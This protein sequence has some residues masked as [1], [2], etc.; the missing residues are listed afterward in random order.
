MGNKQGKKGGA[1]S[2]APGDQKKTPGLTSAEFLSSSGPT[3]PKP[4]EGE[5]EWEKSN[6]YMMGYEPARDVLN[7]K[8]TIKD[9]EL[10]KVVGK[11]SF[12]KVYQVKHIA[13]GEIYALKSLKKQHLLRRKQIAHTQT[14]RKVL[15]QIESPF[16]VNLRFAF[17]DRDRLYMVLDYFTGGEL[18]YHLKTGGRFGYQ[19]AR[20]Y[21][22]EIC[23][24]LECL[25]NN[26]IIYRDLKPE[27][28]LLD[29]EGHIRLTDFGLSKDCMIGNQ[30]TK[31]FCGT[32]EYLAPEVIVGKSYT[33]A[34]DW[35]SFGTVVY[36]MTCGLPPFYHKNVKAM[37]ERI[38]SAPLRFPR[39]MPLEGKDFF[40]KILDRNPKTRLGTKYGA[41]GV[42][43]SPY[44]SDVNWKKASQKEI[45]PLFVPR[46][47]EGKMDAINVDQEFLNEMPSETPMEGSNLA[48]SA[49]AEAFPNFTYTD[50]D[51]ALS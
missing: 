36:E 48:T 42:K 40:T 13:S 21:A 28:I 14:E 11:G 50:G 46:G 4:R 32:P 5:E 23:L 43:K 34:V 38:L 3:S 7:E 29:D 45:N 26:D 24:A 47:K 31:T 51:N 12:G 22:V 37:Y 6:S 44:F 27:N 25:H 17:Q 1:G 39:G 9:F 30:S 10:M 2:A 15:Q 19:R 18:F 8:M 20:F 49:A 41:R 16:I 35:W 33:K